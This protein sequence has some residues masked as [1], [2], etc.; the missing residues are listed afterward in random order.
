MS[1][2]TKILL[3]IFDTMHSPDIIPYRHLVRYHASSCFLLVRC[4]LSLLLTCTMITPN[5]P[6]GLSHEVDGDYVEKW[7]LAHHFPH[8]YSHPDG[9]ANGGCLKWPTSVMSP[10]ARSLI[11]VHSFT[12][13][14]VRAMRLMG[15]MLRHRC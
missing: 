2:F 5:C 4:A 11:H 14:L 13:R 6:S 1:C 12:V 10:F 8:Y 15:I 9:D 7:M 3:L